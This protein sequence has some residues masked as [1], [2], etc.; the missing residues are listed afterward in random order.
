MRLVSQEF[1]EQ[2]ELDGL[3]RPRLNPGRDDCLYF[4][5]VAQGMVLVLV[6]VWDRSAVFSSR[7]KGV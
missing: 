6:A 1:Q 5:Y 7:M 4:L 3:F 2:G